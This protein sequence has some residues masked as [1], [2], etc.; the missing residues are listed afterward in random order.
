MRRLVVP[1]FTPHCFFCMFYF[2]S[3]MISCI[4]GFFFC[5]HNYYQMTFIEDVICGKYDDEHFI[6]IIGPSSLNKPLK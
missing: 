2:L 5:Y 3:Y 4:F 1:A 6:C